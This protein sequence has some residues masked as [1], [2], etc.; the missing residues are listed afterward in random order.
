MLETKN[1]TQRKMATLT[2]PLLIQ[3]PGYQPRTQ[4]HTHTKEAASKGNS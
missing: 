4:T 3:T 1:K 2:D